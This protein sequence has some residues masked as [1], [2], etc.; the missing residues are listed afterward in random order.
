MTDPSPT[1]VGQVVEDRYLVE[2]LL[3]RGAMGTVY[4]A[5]HMKVGREV[6]IKVMHE[7]LTRDPK[8]VARFEREAALAARL[9]HK[10]LVAVL[11]V[12]ETPYGQQFMVL[13]LARG[14]TLAAALANGPLRPARVIALVKQLL[15]GLDHAHRAGLVHRDLKPENVVLERDDHGDE[16]PRIL[17]FGIAVLRE[18]D[19]TAAGQRLTDAGSVLGTPPYM[20]PEQ[21]FGDAPDPRT[22][23]FALGVMTYELLCGRQPFS[24]TGVEIMLS[25]IN[26]DPPPLAERAPGVVVEPALEAFARKLMARTLRDR[27]AS[28]HDA[29]AALAAIRLDD[30]GPRR[31]L[32]TTRRPRE[33]MPALTRPNTEPTATLAPSTADA[34]DDE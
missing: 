12:G 28:A 11:D 3:G 9:T 23:L 15:Q 2:T 16:V 20:A 21:A 13:E 18:R 33:V 4:R 8:M 7:E 30:T 17:D 25:N 27:F 1:L 5:R 6:A 24:G 22:D 19:D 10:N 34:D 29:L 31:A 32:Q 14:E 26:H